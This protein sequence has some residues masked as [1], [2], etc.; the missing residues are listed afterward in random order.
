MNL[1]GPP[2]PRV[3]KGARGTFS[4]IGKKALVPFMF[5]MRK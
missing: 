1:A 4:M 5:R 2:T 3:V